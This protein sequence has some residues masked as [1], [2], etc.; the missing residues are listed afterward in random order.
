MFSGGGIQGHT[1]N[2]FE[3]CAPQN[4][5]YEKTTGW[6][7]YESGPDNPQ[8]RVTTLRGS[9]EALHDVIKSPSALRVHPRL[10]VLSKPHCH[11]GVMTIVIIFTSALVAFLLWK[12]ERKFSRSGSLLSSIAGPKREHW[13]KG[14]YTCLYSGAG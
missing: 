7:L 11:V 6:F 10:I 12:F 13:L 4:L 8:L 9:F 2:A 3:F 1:A 5:M 14:Q